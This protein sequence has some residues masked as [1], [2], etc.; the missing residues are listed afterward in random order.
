M[1]DEQYFPSKNEDYNI[2]KLMHWYERLYLAIK[3]YV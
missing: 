1:C 2:R 3:N